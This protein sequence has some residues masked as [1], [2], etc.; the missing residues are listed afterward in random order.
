MGRAGGSRGRSLALDPLDP[1]PGHRWYTQ[2]T[3]V[4]R[5]VKKRFAEPHGRQHFYLQ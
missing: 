2:C 5:R 4:K 3:P 1:E